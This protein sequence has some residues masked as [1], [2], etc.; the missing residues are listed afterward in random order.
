M[1]AFQ[2]QFLAASLG[3]STV[4]AVGVA[5]T[6][7]AAPPMYPYPNYNYTLS[8]Q[9]ISTFILSNTYPHETGSGLA[10][11]AHLESTATSLE[12]PTIYASP[13]TKPSE[14][15]VIISIP[16]IAFSPGTK[17]TQTDYGII[18]P[19]GPFEWDTITTTSSAP[20]VATSSFVAVPVQ[21][22]SFPGGP[23]STLFFNHEGPDAP[24]PTATT[25]T[26]NGVAVAA[27]SPGVTVSGTTY[28]L[29]PSGDAIYVDGVSADLPVYDQTSDGSSAFEIEGT[30]VAAGSPAVTIHGVTYSLAPSG[31][32]LNV[33]GAE[34]DLSTSEQS[35]SGPGAYDLDGTRIA[36]GSSAVDVA[37]TAYSL[38][39]DG[40]AIYVDGASLSI[41]TQTGTAGQDGFGD[42]VM[43]VI[44]GTRGASTIELTVPATGTA[45]A[46]V[47]DLVAAESAAATSSFGAS[48]ASSS[49]SGASDQPYASSGSSNLSMIPGLGLG[50][51][52]IA[53]LVL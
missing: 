36:A 42:A 51:A 10:N 5:Y 33:D 45:S 53:L 6:V 38:A 3:W 46:S 17:S 27:G 4:A 34:V 1:G 28:S 31:D 29:A 23:Q 41:P 37:G 30:P 48:D 35:S 8:R 21:D 24:S 44:G 9:S 47:L 19:S 11:A 13:A 49:P 20:F 39:P 50:L 16:T 40:D 12:R 14:T 15:S 7:D 43:S 32:I 18:T 22:T 2:A 26:V 25:V 52:M